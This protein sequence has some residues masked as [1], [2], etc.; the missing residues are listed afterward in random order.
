M[1][2]VHHSH[3]IV[4]IKTLQELL[5]GIETSFREMQK[6]IKCDMAIGEIDRDIGDALI[7][8]H[9]GKIVVLKDRLTQ[10]LSLEQ[11]FKECLYVARTIK[12]IEGSL[13]HYMGFEETPYFRKDDKK[14]DIEEYMNQV[15]CIV[16]L[17]N[18]IAQTADDHEKVIIVDNNELTRL[19]K[20]PKSAITMNK[21]IVARSIPLNADVVSYNRRDTKNI[22]EWMNQH[23]DD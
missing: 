8:S 18:I 10:P 14:A 19:K 1:L 20:Y 2:V 13:F 12:N 3:R 4:Y 5:D 6:D 21:L 22:Y 9:A 7:L 16:F 15:C 11:K 23:I 17:S